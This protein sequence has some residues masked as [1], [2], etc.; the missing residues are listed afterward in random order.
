MTGK[1][2]RATMAPMIP[3]ASQQRYIR[4]RNAAEDA[5]K[6]AEAMGNVSG[7]RIA[8]AI[9]EGAKRAYEDSL[10]RHGDLWQGGPLPMNELNQQ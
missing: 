3:T 7:A 10:K 8:K 2:E 9:Y 5:Y 4:Q 6:A 1:P